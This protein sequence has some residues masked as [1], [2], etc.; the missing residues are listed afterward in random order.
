MPM[1]K[2]IKEQSVVC[3]HILTNTHKTLIQPPFKNY[4][5]MKPN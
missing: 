3:K 2:I 5:A 1:Q 4:I